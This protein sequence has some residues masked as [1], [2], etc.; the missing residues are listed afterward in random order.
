MLLRLKKYQK[1]ENIC[2][3]EKIYNF[4][5][6]ISKLQ[7]ATTSTLVIFEINDVLIIPSNHDDDFSY[8]Y[9][10]ELLT[11]MLTRLKKNADVLQSIILSSTK[12]VLV[13]DEIKNIF[14]ILQSKH[15]PAIALTSINTGKFGIIPS[16]ENLT[17]KT[18]K[19][20]GISF[21]ALATKFKNTSKNSTSPNEPLLKSGI[22]FTSNFDK[23]E[24]LSYMFRKHNY[25]PKNIISIDNNLNSFESLKTLCME[26]NINFCAFDYNKSPLIP[27]PTIDPQLEKLRFEILEKQLVWLSYKQLNSILFHTTTGQI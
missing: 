3:P 7:L 8:P 12:Y 14:N 16:M 10:A 18:L 13:D 5:P 25:Y 15:I 17:I 2:H 21:K 11:S 9:R 26:L 22:V 27:P 1:N 20:V 4:S 19:N 24:A 23:G 6:V